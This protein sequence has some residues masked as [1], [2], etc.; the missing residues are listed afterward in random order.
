MGID[1][2]RSFSFIE[3]PPEGALND[4]L[5]G[6]QEHGAVDEDEKITPLGH[7]LSQL[8][9]EVSIGKFKSIQILIILAA[10]RRSVERVA[11]FISAA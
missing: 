3:S 6:L 11:R 4:A 8:P 2:V 10:L 5:R 1:D 7:M 9:V